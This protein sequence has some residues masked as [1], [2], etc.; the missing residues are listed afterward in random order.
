MSIE[1]L[2]EGNN[3][4]WWFYNWGI[5]L[6]EAKHC[7]HHISKGKF[8]SFLYLHIEV[9]TLEVFQYS[10]EPWVKDNSWLVIWRLTAHFFLYVM[11]KTKCFP[12]NL[13]SFKIEFL[14]WSLSLFYFMLF[15]F[16]VTTWTHMSKLNSSTFPISVLGTLQLFYCMDPHIIFTTTHI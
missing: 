6:G 11:Y 15:S 3:N 14:I 5:F 16:C 4:T 2:S 8:W 10:H 1:L 13:L 12:T 7:Q 9:H